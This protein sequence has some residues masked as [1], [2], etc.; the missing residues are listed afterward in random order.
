[1]WVV[2]DG[3]VAAIAY[4]SLKGEF[5]LSVSQP[6]EYQVQA[7]FSGKKVGAPVTIKVTA[8]DIDL[9][10]TPIVVAKKDS[11]G[12]KEKDKDKSDDADKS[13]PEPAGGTADAGVTH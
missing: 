10:K 9:A 1:M 2:G 5:Q 3:N 11:S 13:N 12:A 6:G 4:P 7:F 8:A